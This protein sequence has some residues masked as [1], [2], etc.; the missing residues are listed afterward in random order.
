MDEAIRILENRLNMLQ[1]LRRMR[2]N[3]IYTIYNNDQLE[4][5]NSVAT[6]FLSCKNSLEEINSEIIL[7]PRIIDLLKQNI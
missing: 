2:E 6:V 5:C 7:L 4:H 1:R 3:K